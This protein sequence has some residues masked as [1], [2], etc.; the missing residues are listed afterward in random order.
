MPILVLPS[1]IS[2]CIKKIMTIYRKH[3]HLGVRLSAFARVYTHTHTHSH[4]HMPLLC[5]KPLTRYSCFRTFALKYKHLSTFVGTDLF[6]IT[7]SWPMMDEIFL[8]IPLPN[9]TYGIVNHKHHIK[10]NFTTWFI[11][12]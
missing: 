1:Q 5:L 2:Q 6:V 10:S 7:E 3:A 9:G 4:K 8:Y 12:T 11:P